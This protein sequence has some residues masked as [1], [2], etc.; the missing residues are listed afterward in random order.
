MKKALLTLLITLSLAMMLSLSAFASDN[1]NVV[2]LNDV[3]Y[4]TLQEAVDVAIT[5][6]SQG[7]QYINVIR[8]IELDTTVVIPKP[9]GNAFAIVIELNGHTITSSASTV[10]QSNSFLGLMDNAS[11]NA[12]SIICTAENGTVIE[13][14]SML[15]VMGVKKETTIGNGT[16]YA[17]KSTGFYCDISDGTYLGSIQMVPA[18]PMSVIRNGVFSEDPSPYVDSKS[19]H[20]VCENGLYVATDCEAKIGDEW[21]ENIEDAFS[22]ANDGDTIT[23]LKQNSICVTIEKDITLDLNGCLLT[24]ADN[25]T[26]ITVA[27]GA[28]LTVI[29]SVGTGKMYTASKNQDE[30]I[31]VQGEAVILGGAIGYNEKAI[32]VA[33]GGSLVVDGGTIKG[34]IASEGGDVSVTGGSFNT[35]VNSDHIAKGYKSS[36]NEDGT[37]SIVEWVVTVEEIFVCKGYSVK[38][39]GSGITIGYTF[40]QDAYELYIEQNNAKIDFGAVFAIDSI[41]ESAVRYSLSSYSKTAEYCV[42]IYDIDEENFDTKLTMAIYLTI[43]GETGY[44]TNGVDGGS[45]V[46]ADASL[47]NS[48]TYNK[49]SGK[50]E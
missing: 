33:Q 31:N 17:I 2:S 30:T 40:N 42:S 10:I 25:T 6:V 44:V 16:G 46:T 21:Y 13:S 7:P 18:P 22:E 5:K 39:G 37:Y 32:V 36:A 27:K 43:N 23:V 15:S 19:C 11:E 14:S 29:D 12:G 48:T 38:E 4:A 20:V 47:V 28:K 1:A 26:N 41:D 8:D 50:E 49:A 3:E 34:A 24:C 35:P 45:I 9:S